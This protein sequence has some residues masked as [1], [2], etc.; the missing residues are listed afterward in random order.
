MAKS[1]PFTGEISSGMLSDIGCRYVIVGHS[2]R[3]KH[4]GETDAMVNQKAL[5]AVA[6]GLKVILCVGEGTAEAGSRTN[7]VDRVIEEQFLRA[8]ERFPV[9]ASRDLIVAYEPVWAIGTGKTATSDNAVQAAL[10][11]R[12]LAVKKFG[13]KSADRL[14]VLYGGSVSNKTVGAFWREDQLDGV[15]VGSA[16][17]NAKEFTDLLKSI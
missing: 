14:R 1:G 9:G 12:K 5:A 2:E 11:M 15:L 16:S 7:V 3:R 8:T 4:L 6:A 13:R 17:A 10:L